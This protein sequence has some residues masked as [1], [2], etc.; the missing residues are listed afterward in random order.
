VILSVAVAVAAG[1][2]A[3]ARWAVGRRISRSS[4][5]AFPYG[6]LVVNVSGSFLLGVVVGLAGHQGLDPE[7]ALVLGTGFAGGYT[8]LSTW[9]YETW[10]LAEARAMLAAVTNVVGSFAA[11]MLAAG[12]GL[13]AT[14][15]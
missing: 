9:A 2:G 13:A 15:L 14:Q 8:T 5:A 11:A 3:V 1:L 7:V 4:P 6:T 10:V 12:A